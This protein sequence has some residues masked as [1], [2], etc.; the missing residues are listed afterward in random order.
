[1]DEEPDFVPADDAG[2][3]RARGTST[4]LAKAIAIFV[5]AT[6][7]IPASPGLVWFPKYTGGECGEQTVRLRDRRTPE[8]NAAYGMLQFIMR[9][10]YLLI[11][12]LGVC[13][14]MAG[15]AT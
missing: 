3:A 15:Q 7:C 12:I 5:L 8:V 4:R 1:M 13:L 9:H 14:V 6:V 10:T 2:W 11:A